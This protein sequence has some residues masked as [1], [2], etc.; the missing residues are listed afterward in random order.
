MTTAPV[1]SRWD[2]VSA[3]FGTASLRHTHWLDATPREF[4][5]APG[6]W[7]A[8]ADGVHGTD[9]PESGAVVLAPF[10]QVREGRLLLR[11]FARDGAHALRVFDPEAPGRL[12]LTGIES[13]PADDAWRVR[14]RFT[15]APDGATVTVR[16][17]DGHERVAPAGGTIDLE[18]AGT[19]VHLSVAADEDGLSAVI[20]D[21]TASDG[22]YRFRFLPID[23]PAADGT[24]E[25]DFGRAY[26][27]PCAF[28]DEYVCPLPPAGNRF[29]FPIPAGERRALRAGA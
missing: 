8:D 29:A 9:L 16:S 7:W 15:P 19:P 27:P 11:A 26:L 24:V 2:A 25:V 17:V 12:A 6:R 4:E 5:G 13:F 3:P 21:A 28:S 20:A 22:A 14:G 1:A 10:E 18:V 23:L